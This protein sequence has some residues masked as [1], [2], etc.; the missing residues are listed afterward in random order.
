MRFGVLGELAVWTDG[1]APVGVPGAKVR[2]LL[3][4]LLVYRG[5][6]VTADRLC[7]EL[8]DAPPP[9]PAAALQTTVSRLRRAL[10]RGEAGYRGR[11]ES[12]PSGYRLRVGPEQVDAG[13]FEALADRARGA[14]PAEAAE[15]LGR[16]L[17]L[18]RGPALAGHADAPFAR[19]A[20]ARWE[21]RRL[22]AVE[23]R[24]R[25]RLELGEDAALVP[26]LDGHVRRHPARER[27]RAA[28]MLALYRSGRQSEA[29]ESYQGLRTL[30]A[31]ELGVDPG[32]EIAR[33]YED[34]LRQ[35][36][37]L[38]SPAEDGRGPGLGPPGSPGVTGVTGVTGTT[39]ATET[40]GS[41]GN[42]PSA[43]EWATVPIRPPGNLPAPLTDVVGRDACVPRVRADLE[44]NRL[45]TLFGP[46]GVGKTTLALASV[47]C[48]DPR[49][50]DVWFVELA[51]REPSARAE[52]VAD[53]IAVA[54]GVRDEEHTGNRPGPRPCSDRVAESLG[55]GPV[56]LVLDNCEHVVAPVSEVVT[57]LLRCVPGLRV[58]ATS[59]EPLGVPGER[60]HQVRPLGV[61]RDATSAGLAGSSAVELFTR[62]VSASVPGFAVD[63][64]NAEAVASVC[65]RLDGLPLAL[66]LAAARVRSLGVHELAVR[67]DD[68]FRV[69]GS[70]GAGV[71]QRQRTLHAVVDWSWQ[72]LSAAERAVLRRLAVQA[73]TFT[74]A[75]AEA[76]ATGPGVPRAEVAGLLARLV[77]RSLVVAEQDRR[78]TRYRMLE[79]IRAFAR[80]RLDEAGEAEP[81]LYRHALHV[82]DETVGAASRSETGL[83]R[84]EQLD[85]EMANTR[86]AAEWAAEH[87]HADPALRI[88]GSLGWY[89]YLRGRY[90]EGHRLLSLALSAGGGASDGD[91]A[92]ALLWHAALEFADGPG[93]GGTRSAE[94]AIRLAD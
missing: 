68:R 43:G 7:E 63:A 64:D 42:T 70:S 8:W 89:W 14:A 58:L 38:D 81:T 77:D 1:G 46:G 48:G 88:T 54:M 16:A 34:I 82:A 25:A 29:L 91:R 15:L 17:D 26:E 67:L 61:P 85:Q 72:P 4:V 50:G 92:T 55:P 60:L 83:P 24:A 86:A 57:R 18:W 73:G 51:G 69:L 53:D 75:A 80:D 87:G 79:T 44:R 13:R 65:R 66:E 33:L 32:P 40:V 35:S 39:M 10:E 41:P 76:V 9:D 90:R 47:A 23:E 6:P 71:H 56:L 37:A 78:G 22:V 94:E 31:E 5:E 27:L 49:F 52:D 74:L 84:F 36:P 19:A 11:V 45:V 28:H 30:L 20:V 59:R 93:P 62:R 3:A 2:S 12:G 21:E